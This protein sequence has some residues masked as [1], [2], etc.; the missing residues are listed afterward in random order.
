VSKTALQLKSVLED[1][2]MV[3]IELSL[4]CYIFQYREICKL[5]IRY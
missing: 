2:V 1:K 5:T 3:F 4:L